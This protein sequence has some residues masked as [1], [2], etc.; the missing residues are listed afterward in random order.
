MKNLLFLINILVGIII[1][2]NL[3]SQEDANKQDSIRNKALKL[4]IDCRS[5]DMNYTRQEIPYVNYVRDTREAQVYLLVSNQN[6]GSGGEQYTLTYEG[7]GIYKGMNDTLV[8]TS[9]PDETNTIIREKKTNY[10]KIG[11][12]R[13]VAKTP[14]V[15]KIKISN[16]T[17]LEQEEVIDKWNNWVFELQT[18]P[19]YNAEESYKR[20]FFSNSVNIARVTP[21]IK[22]EMEFDMNNNTQKFIEEG[23]ETTYI[24]KERSARNLFV[25]S[26]GE[27]WSAGLKWN[28]G[29][30]TNE[31]YDF[32]SEFLPSVEYDLFPYSEA[33]HR[34]MRF[35]YSAGYQYSNYIDTTIF[36]QTSENLYK[37]SLSI[38]YQVQRKW[39][40][41]NIS[42]SGSNYF[43]DL[44]KNRVELYGFIRLRIIKGLSLSVNG[45]IAY[46][47]DQLNLRKGD[48]TEAERLLRLKEQA[49][50]FSIQGGLSLTYTFGSIYNNVVNPR[51][52][53]GG[54]GY[55]Y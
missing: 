30:S 46:I 29:S 32:A 34:Q 45:G 21:E 51:F 43:H 36:N 38:A 15:D 19:R 53:N 3:K 31:N 17:D 47:N 10:I 25:K 2:I 27:H 54:G 4:F 20:L 49:T 41:V 39:G 13:Y 33:T 48:L 9:N 28:L 1:P 16:S 24:R 23:V 18:S 26:I 42:L 44:S 8:Y 7:L 11:L 37:Q 55:Y 12:M 50:N 22:L 40:S 52:G 35:L 14:L 5:C 6:A